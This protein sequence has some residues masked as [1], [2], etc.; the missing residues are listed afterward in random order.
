MAR[1]D[2]EVAPLNL[3]ALLQGELHV[4]G[5]HGTF[6]PKARNPPT[7]AYGV[8]VLQKQI[9]RKAVEMKCQVSS[10]TEWDQCDKTCGGG[11]QIRHRQAKLRSCERAMKALGV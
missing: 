3:R 2:C 4:D 8:G 5:L 9:T 7:V 1:V 10:W 11:Q 6:N